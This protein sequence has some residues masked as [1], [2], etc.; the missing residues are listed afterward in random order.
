MDHSLREVLYG[1]PLQ[2]FLFSKYPLSYAIH[3][4]STI[5]GDMVLNATFHNIKVISWR[6]VLLVEDTGV[7]GENQ[8]PTANH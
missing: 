7:P 4:L 3:Y 5:W 1:G 8:R 2:S 6:P